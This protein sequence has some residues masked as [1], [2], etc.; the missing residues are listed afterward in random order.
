[1]LVRDWFMVRIR[2]NSRYFDEVASEFDAEETL[3]AGKE[4]FSNRQCIIFVEQDIV[5]FPICL[6]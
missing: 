3:R 6:M 1:M 2:D 4:Q 5:S